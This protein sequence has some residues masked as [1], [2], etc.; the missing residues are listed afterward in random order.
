[1]I[2]ALDSFLREQKNRIGWDSTILMCPERFFRE[3][4]AFHQKEIVDSG[5]S[6]GLNEL[7]IDNSKIT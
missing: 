1:M 3:E 6:E 5:V 7:D 2:E 4:V